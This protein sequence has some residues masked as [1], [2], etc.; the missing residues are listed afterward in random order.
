MISPHI[1]HCLRPVPEAGGCDSSLCQAVHHGRE[2]G[3]AQLRPLRLTRETGTA[4]K[5]IPA[6]G[7]HWLPG[8]RH[9][10]EFESLTHFNQYNDFTLLGLVSYLKLVSGGC[11]TGKCPVE[12]IH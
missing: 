3:P 5:K 7:G 2:A 1:C 4:D 9:E 11:W 8:P 10:G 6:D 12:T